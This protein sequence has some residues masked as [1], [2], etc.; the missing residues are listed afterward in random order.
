MKTFHTGGVVGGG[1]ALVDGI[2]RVIQLLKIPK[3]LPNAATLSPSNNKITSIKKSPV[4]GYD[5]KV[6]NDDVYVPGNRTLSVKVGDT[7]K[8]GQRMTDGP[9]DPRRLLELTNVDTVQR[10]MTDELHKIYASQGIKR[11]NVEVI[12]KSITNL[13]KIDDPG[14]SNEFIRGDYASISYVN[15]LN[16]KKPGNPIK[17]S[18][19]LRGIETFRLIKQ[20]TLLQD[21]STES[22]RKH[23]YEQ[24]MRAGNLISTD[25]TQHR[26]SYTQL[27]LGKERRVHTDDT[28]S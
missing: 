28:H 17:I 19:V 3:I 22:L 12:I 8:K 13:G 24:L 2:D 14:D 16:K 25:S 7:L 18:P 6:G 15:A 5:I 21:F 26:E 27:S 9:I 20:L 11:K 23:S 1:S 4:G 10:Y